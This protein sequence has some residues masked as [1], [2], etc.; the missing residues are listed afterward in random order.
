MRW[1]T[2]LVAGLLAAPAAAA[3]LSALGRTIRKEL[4]YAGRPRYCLLVFGPEARDRVWLVHDGD[5]LYVDRNGNGDLTDPGEAVAAQRDKDRD[6][7]EFGYRFEV[8]ELRVGGR[9]HKELCERR[10]SPGQPS[11]PTRRPASTASPSVSIGRTS[12]GGASTGG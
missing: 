12:G 7:E 2:L 1:T 6:P 9:V 5:A 11:P 10:R 3:D 4:A 8:G